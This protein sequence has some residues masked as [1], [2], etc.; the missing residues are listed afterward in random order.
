MGLSVFAADA[1]EHAEILDKRARD[2]ADQQLDKVLGAG[3][4]I[5]AGEPC[6]AR[7]LLTYADRRMAASPMSV[8]RA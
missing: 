5:C 1:I 6:D 2:V 4:G 3:Y 7:R 8:L